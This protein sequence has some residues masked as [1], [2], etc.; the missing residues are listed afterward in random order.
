MS[1]G[2]NFFHEDW[3]LQRERLSASLDGELDAAEREQLERHLVECERCRA[4]L[5]ELRQTRGLLRAL[6]QPALPRS[7]ML[8]IETPANVRS[9]ADAPSNAARSRMRSGTFSRLAQ[10]V[11][12]LAAAVGIVLLLGTWIAGLHGASV[13]SN[14]SKVPQGAGASQNTQ[15]KTAGAPATRTSP[16][17]AGA[18][19]APEGA[20]GSTANPGETQAASTATAAANATNS[21]AKTG[22]S[23]SSAPVVPLTGAGLLVG[24][25]ALVVAGKTTR[26]RRGRRARGQ[27]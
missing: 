7:F 24:G 18:T 2:T 20:T 12:S 4:I 27:P 14:A 5:A 15:Q 11:G 13:A 6:P 9:I 26:T 19:R 22:S 1:S 23:A 16:V 3:D 25:I 10:R 17:F 21:H 8:P